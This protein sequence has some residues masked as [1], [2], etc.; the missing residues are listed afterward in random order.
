MAMII[1]EGVVVGWRYF[2]ARPKDRIV[3]EEEKTNKKLCIFVGNSNKKKTHLVRN[4]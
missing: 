1:I 3:P 4:K 2:K